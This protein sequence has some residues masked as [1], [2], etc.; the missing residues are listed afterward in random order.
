LD[1]IDAELAVAEAQAALES[2]Q[3][4]LNEAEAN[5]ERV[6]SI[7]ESGVTTESALDA[8]VRTL[9]VAQAAEQRAHVNLDQAR[10]VLGDCTVESP[11]D[12]EVTHRM[13]E[14]GEMVA[15][16][17]PAIEVADL[18]RVKFV[19][20]VS[21]R[22]RVPLTIGQ[23]V[24][25]SVDSLRG[26]VFAGTIYALGA[27]ADSQTLTFPIEIAIDNADG[28]LLGGMIAR[29]TLVLEERPGRLI[30]PLGARVQRVD[31]EGV[32]AAIS[33]EDG[34]PEA[35]FVEVEFG[36]RQGHFIEVISGLEEGD[37][38]IARGAEGLR[39]GMALRIA[40]RN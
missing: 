6:A 14:T 19:A 29:A 15:A 17:S 31:G 40:E 26:E 30:A 8:A 35:H 36:D 33:G 28:R 1:L 4:T 32:F 5:H 10:E 25:I 20:E 23:T 37:E 18:S 3:A 39:E 9:A 21:A 12:G 22:E 13:I 2:A 16:G 27:N 34:S 11:I 38:L 24:Q 7:A